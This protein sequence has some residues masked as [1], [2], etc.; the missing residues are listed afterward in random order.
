MSNSFVTFDVTF[1]VTF[2]VTYD[3]DF[4][5]GDQESGVTCQHIRARPSKS[6]EAAATEP[7]PPIAVPQHAITLHATAV[8]EVV[9]LTAAVE[10]GDGLHE[11][12]EVVAEVEDDD[13]LYWG[14]TK[15]FN[16]V[17][18]EAAVSSAQWHGRKQFKIFFEDLENDKIAKNIETSKNLI[19]TSIL[20]EL[21]KN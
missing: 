12:V 11:E 7:Q 14:R 15:C 8:T 16:A 20:E 5:D 3:V 13:D 17:L 19:N 21:G 1:V 10:T 6:A 4:D 18:A 9:E 2:D